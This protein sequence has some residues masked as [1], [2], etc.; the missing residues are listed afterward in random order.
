MIKN[1]WYAVEFGH[2]I[3]SKPHQVR[4][5]GQDLVLYRNT[6]G[7]IVCHS[8]ICIHRGASLAGGKV[9]GD[10]VECPYH[11]WQ[12]DT[13]GAC[14]KIPAN[15]AGSPIPKKAR[16]DN[17]PCVEKY[18]YVFVF[19]GDLPEN[20]RP[21][22]A[23]LPGMADTCEARAEGNRIVQGE[24]AW[25]ANYERV[26]ENGADAAHAPFVHSTSFGNPNKPEI[27]DF[28]LVEHR[29]GDHLMGATYVVHLEPPDP[30]GIWKVLRRGKE[31]PPVATGNGVFFPN[32]TFL[33]VNL[34][35]GVMTIF[36]AVVPVDENHSI[37]KWTMM[38]TFFTQPWAITLLRA[39]KDSYKRT[40]KIFY[41]DRATVEGQRPE[42]VPFDL[43]AELQVKSDAVQ[44]A[45][46]RW[47]Q[48]NIDRGWLI[49]EHVVGTGRYEGAKV[50]PSPAR[51]A[52]PELANAW[53]L[54]ELEAKEALRE[55]REVERA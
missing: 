13:D 35:I 9:V 29:V 24:F 14:V 37:S 16:V 54:K 23:E 4:L 32:I 28:D 21:P 12:F 53:V 22:L 11:G 51:R 2:V 30:K 7:E 55:R 48:G 18:G 49:D 52:N 44:L 47:R 42:L 33:Q 6:K 15:K 43:S 31:R 3:G 26:I 45:Y 46:R 25:N 20:E 50:V 17:Y 27:E 1:Q 41:E 34:P 5:F 19:F 38:R 40:M 36:T 39:D 8:D 10:C